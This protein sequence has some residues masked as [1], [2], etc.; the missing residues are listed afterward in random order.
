VEVQYEQSTLHGM[1]PLTWW[2]HV[3]Q[4]LSAVQSATASS[5]STRRDTSAHANDSFSCILMA[6]AKRVWRCRAAALLRRFNWRRVQSQ[7]GAAEAACTR[8]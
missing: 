8:P 3:P 5:G 7:A 1:E 6:K 4:S 2:T